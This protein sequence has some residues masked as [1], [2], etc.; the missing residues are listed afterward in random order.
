MRKKVGIFSTQYPKNTE[1]KQKV[2]QTLQFLRDDK[3]I[4]FVDGKGTYTLITSELLKT[5]AE[6]TENIDFSKEKPEKREYL[7]ETYVRKTKWVKEAKKAYGTDCMYKRCKNTFL[8]PDGAPYIEVH[9]IIPLFK[10]GEELLWNLSVL[11]AH[12]HRMAHFSN[13]QDKNTMEKYL[14][15]EAELRS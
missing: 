6:E 12:H 3:L 7:I 9:H 4:Y 1:I 11:C 10:G 5:E 2:Q 14:L 15:K 8:R 13:E